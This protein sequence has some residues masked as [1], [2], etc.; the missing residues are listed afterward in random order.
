MET[1]A[2]ITLGILVATMGTVMTTM[3]MKAAV[4]GQHAIEQV[5]SLNKNSLLLVGQLTLTCR[6]R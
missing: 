3:Q 2:T 5:A 4:A 6:S 1:P